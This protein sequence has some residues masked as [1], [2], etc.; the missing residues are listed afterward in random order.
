MSEYVHTHTQRIKVHVS[1]LHRPSHQRP[2]TRSHGRTRSW[3]Q[4]P[5]ESSLTFHLQLGLDL[6]LGPDL[7]LASRHGDDVSENLPSLCVWPGGGA[8]T[9]RVL[10]SEG[11]EG[12]AAAGGR[13]CGDDLKEADRVALGGGTREE[14]AVCGDGVGPGRLRLKEGEAEP[15][16]KPGRE[17]GVVAVCQG[18]G[19]ALGLAPPTPPAGARAR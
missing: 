3:R 12:A 9:L 18:V 16:A 5:P 13:S 4:V 8:L 10:L 6:P 14:G 19:G 7:R 15:R 11:E 2:L 1:L 17:D